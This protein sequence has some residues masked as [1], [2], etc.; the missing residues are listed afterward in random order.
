MRNK[1]GQVARFVYRHK[2]KI[3]VL[4]YASQSPAAHRDLESGMTTF[5][6]TTAAIAYW[7]GVATGRI[8]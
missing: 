5:V 8:K 6:G 4:I 2:K 1:A 3:G 7:T